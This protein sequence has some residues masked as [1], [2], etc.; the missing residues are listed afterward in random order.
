M[1]TLFL[2]DTSAYAVA[3][4]VPAAEARLRSLASDGILATFVTV[5]LEL[6][7]SAR[8][9]R[10]HQGIARVRGQLVQLRCT[11]DIAVRARQVQAMLAAQ[12]RHRA[13]GVMDLLTAAAAEQHGAS[14]LHYDADFDHIAAV[15]GQQVDWIAPRG[16]V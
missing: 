11:D 2:A 3:Q 4:R 6:G 14:V 10:E 12:S 13:A 7:Y 9:P 5:D 16:S 1:T 15:T 8:D